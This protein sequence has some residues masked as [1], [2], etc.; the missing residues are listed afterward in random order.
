MTWKRRALL[1][2]IG[3]F[4][5]GLLAAGLLVLSDILVHRGAWAGWLGYGVA[6]PALF[7]AYLALGSAALPVNKSSRRIFDLIT[8]IAIFVSLAPAVV[9]ALNIGFLQLDIA[10]RLALVLMAALLGWYARRWNPLAAPRSEDYL[11]LPLRALDLT[12]QGLLMIA[13]GLAAMFFVSAPVVTL[14]F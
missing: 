12:R 9:V 13:V 4:L 3:S 10:I 7:V 11:P 5:I 1:Y 6:I 8:R 14:V 2:G